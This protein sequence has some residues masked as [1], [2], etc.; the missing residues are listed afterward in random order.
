MKWDVGAGSEAEFRLAVFGGVQRID[1]FGEGFL[2]FALQALS[3]V[4]VE[5]DGVLLIVRH[6]VLC[7]DGFDRT[8]RDT[9]RA[10]D[11]VVGMND[12]A[13]VEDVEASH[14]ANINAIGEPAFDAIVGNYMGHDI[15]F[16]CVR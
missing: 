8:F 10:V 16:S 6:V 3:L 15:S 9:G 4:L 12:E 5:L 2:T 1:A 11:A 7:E 14:G 13:V